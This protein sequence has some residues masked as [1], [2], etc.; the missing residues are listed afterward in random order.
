MSERSCGVGAALSADRWRPARRL[1]GAGRGDRPQAPWRVAGG[2]RPRHP[3]GSAGAG[4][5]PIG[6]AGVAWGD[7]SAG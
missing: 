2:E 1:E 4:P 5:G 3:P 6:A 7:L